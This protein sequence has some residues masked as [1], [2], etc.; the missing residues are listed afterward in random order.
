MFCPQCGART[1]VSETRGPFRD[2]RCTN[3]ACRLE[4]TT[5]E[6]VLSLREH[7]RLCARTRATLAEILPRSLAASAGESSMSAPGPGAP[8][9]PGEG[10]KRVQEE[11]QCK[12]AGEAG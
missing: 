12:Q 1:E 10:A 3:A 2:R 5:H 4:F 6:N 8:S 9:H 11:Q 7:R